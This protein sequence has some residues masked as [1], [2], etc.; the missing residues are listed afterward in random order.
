MRDKNFISQPSYSQI[1]FDT[2]QTYVQTLQ[3]WW[4]QF[5]LSESCNQILLQLP[6]NYTISSRTEIMA[7]SQ[8][9]CTL[10]R[11]QL[12]KRMPPQLIQ[13]MPFKINLF[14]IQFTILKGHLAYLYTASWKWMST[15]LK[16][17]MANQDWSF[18]TKHTG[19]GGS[20]KVN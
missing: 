11:T 1:H 17:N 8:L 7:I 12:Q 18:K 3:E 4:W 2:I 5:Y 10:P 16:I 14:Y 20:N 19:G 9:S 13:L 6:R 15:V